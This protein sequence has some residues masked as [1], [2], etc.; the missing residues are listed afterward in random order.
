MKIIACLSYFDEDPDLLTECI[1]RLKE[2]G[3][4]HLVAV[5]GPYDLYPAE[6]QVS[7]FETVR[8]I[9][10]ACGSQGPDVTLRGKSGWEGNEVEKRNYMLEVALSIAEEGDWL[11]VVDADHMWELI[12]PESG[13]LK[14]RLG[15][16]SLDVAEVGF[17]DWL[18]S[19]PNWYEAR[20]LNRAV[21]GMHYV[22]AH[23]R[24][25]F[26]DGKDSAVLRNGAKAGDK[27]T[28][29]LRSFA[30]VR[31]L[32]YQLSPERRER[33]AKYYQERHI[34]QVES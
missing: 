13:S 19:D 22:G 27:E 28:L 31:H 7:P 23:W 3:V 8:A 12:E 24:L 26:P 21:P 9:L 33:Q 16:T 30:R 20:L 11:L 25:R 2:V 15:V 4:D 18:G 10:D 6:R 1:G 29:D 34:K 5:D 32:V 14:E 17:A